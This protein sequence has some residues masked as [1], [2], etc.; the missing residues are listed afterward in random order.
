M[1]SLLFKLL[2]T[3]MERDYSTVEV[4]FL[5]PLYPILIPHIALSKLCMLCEIGVIQML[6]KIF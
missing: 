4:G 1:F 5:S 2:S 3:F 6:S